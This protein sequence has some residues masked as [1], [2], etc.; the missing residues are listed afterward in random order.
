MELLEV[1]NLYKEFYKD[2]V[3]F[4]AVDH[5]HFSIREGECLGLVGESGCGKSTTASLIAGLLKP[6]KGTF[7]FLG[8]ELTKSSSRRIRKNIQMIFQ[9]P[10]DSFDPRYHLLSSVQQG[11][12]YVEKCDKRELERRAQEAI[13]FVGLKESYYKKPI[14]QLSGGE[15]QRAAIARAIIGQP[16]LLICDEATSALDVS[17]QAQIISLL[18]S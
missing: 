5:I 3:K 18:K 14:H 16:K 6:D 12:R 15:C 17:V 1:E 13:S 7:R 9:N 11:L 4:A 8:E 10:M 2:K